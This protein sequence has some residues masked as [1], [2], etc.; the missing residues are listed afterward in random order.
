M[1]VLF[2]RTQKFV[3]LSTSVAQYVA[4]G[5]AVK[6]FLFLRQICRSM[7]PG[8]GMPCF[9]VSEDNQGAL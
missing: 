7:I 6:E 5:D 2:S 3:P 1:R 4:L 9:P 8:K